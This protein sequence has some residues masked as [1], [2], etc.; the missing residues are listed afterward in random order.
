MIWILSRG[1]SGSAWLSAVLTA[2]GL[3]GSHENVPLPQ[4]QHDFRAHT[5]FLWDVK[6]TLRDLEQRGLHKL[7]DVVVILER[8]REEIEQS[9][10]KIIGVEENWS[11]LHREWEE[12]KT[13]VLRTS[14][15]LRATFTV[16]YKDL[17]THH[18]E[19]TL[20]A[21]LSASRTDRVKPVGAWPESNMYTAKRVLEVF[22]HLRVT[23]LTDERR[24]QNSYRGDSVSGLIQN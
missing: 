14:G 2:C 5:G 3:N 7:Q 21:I 8:P 11:H 1:R 10:A 9:I 6:G 18:F 15:L 20:A 4:P 16:Q 22:R 17:F 13:G 12:L 24:T 19:A 23:N